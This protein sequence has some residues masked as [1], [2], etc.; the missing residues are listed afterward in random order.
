MLHSHFNI[1][2]SRIT[3]RAKDKISCST[4]HFR[5]QYPRTKPC[6]AAAD[7]PS[8]SGAPRRARAQARAM[9]CGAGI[10]DQ[11]NFRKFRNASLWPQIWCLSTRLKQSKNFLLSYVANAYLAVRVRSRGTMKKQLRKMTIFWKA[12]IQDLLNQ[13]AWNFACASVIPNHIDSENYS[14][15]RFIW[16]TEINFSHPASRKMTFCKKVQKFWAPLSQPLPPS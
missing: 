4:N 1:P 3:L 8:R 13:F 5:I 16:D 15:I 10:C 6:W 11:M 7:W 2:V 9:L 12:R 14:F